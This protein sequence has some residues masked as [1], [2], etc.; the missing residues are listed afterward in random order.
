MEPS[1]PGPLQFRTAVPAGGAASGATCTECSTPIRGTYWTIGKQ[2]F[3]EACRQKLLAVHGPDARPGWGGA[4]RALLFGGGAALAGAALY[5]AVV[6]FLGIEAA[7]ITILIGWMVGKAV[8]AGTRGIGAR[9]YQALAVVLTYFAIAIV[10]VPAA[11][12]LSDRAATSGLPKFTADS[13]R[14]ANA[15]AAYALNARTADDSIKAGI[16]PPAGDTTSETAERVAR[17]RARVDTVRQRAAAV[18]KDTSLVYPLLAIGIGVPIVIATAPVRVILSDLPGSLLTL[19]IIFVGLAQAWRIPA[20]LELR[21]HG[22][23]EMA[24]APAPPTAGDADSA[25]PPD[26]TPPA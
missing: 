24:P 26:A 19:L 3:C 5:V 25:A 14:A 7:L 6:Y 8:R 18:P 10:Y 1:P 23:Y 12:E 20:P 22:P 2:L 9:R 13:L 16:L 21:F 11:L 17:A 15:E 4:V